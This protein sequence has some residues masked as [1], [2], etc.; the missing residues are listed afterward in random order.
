MI[1]QKSRGVSHGFQL[2]LGIVLIDTMFDENINSKS[3]PRIKNTLSKEP[4][5][6]VRD[7]TDRI[8][9]EPRN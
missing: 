7:M 3:S 6:G 9:T 4:Q 2:S 1:Q 5:N 8:Y